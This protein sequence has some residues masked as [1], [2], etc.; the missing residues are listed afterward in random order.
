MYKP[1]NAKGVKKNVVVQKLTS[2]PQATTTSQADFEKT[3]VAYTCETGASY[4]VYEVTAQW[5]EDPDLTHSYFFLDLWEKIG[6]D[7]AKLGVG[8]RWT[9]IF[10]SL[11]GQSVM[12][13][14]ITLPAY[15]GTRSYKLRVRSYGS[16]SRD[17]TFNE[18]ED[19]NRFDPII[20]MY[21]VM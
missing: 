21:S 18:D 5:H 4:V 7:W 14:A 16:A 15:T 6:E 20:K 3:E 8:Y 11:S 12:S 2:T 13:C 1:K 9:E 17:A 10:Q 19:G